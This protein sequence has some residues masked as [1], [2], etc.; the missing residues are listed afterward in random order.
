MESGGLSSLNKPSLG[1]SSPTTLGNGLN[2]ANDFPFS[3][4]NSTSGYGNTIRSGLDSTNSGGN[5][6]TGYGNTLNT[7]N[8]GLDTRLNGGTK[9]GQN[10]LYIDNLSQSRLF[11]SSL[12][13][14]SDDK[15][16]LNLGLYNTYL[17]PRIQL[18]NG[19]LVADNSNKVY[20]R[21]QITEDQKRE[22]DERIRREML[23]ELASST[24]EGIEP[25]PHID[26]RCNYGVG[27]GT[28]IHNKK[29][30]NEMYDWLNARGEPAD[31]ALLE[32]AWQNGQ[33]LINEN[34]VMRNG[35]AYCPTIPK[36]RIQAKSH[37]MGGVHI[38]EADAIRLADEFLMTKTF[39]QLKQSLKNMGM[40]YY[41]DFSDSG[42][43]VM[44]HGQYNLGKGPN[45]IPSVREGIL[46]NDWNKVC[47]GYIPST[48]GKDRARD[49]HGKC[50]VEQGFQDERGKKR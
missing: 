19:V 39:P 29:E 3:W 23:E 49:L 32:E 12:G 33:T 47:Q 9:N 45:A 13:S 26:T 6:D 24:H 35:K 43:K 37:G 34:K 50:G 22:I 30:F 1:E 16:K 7:A 31:A 25:T 20:E 27:I 5:L 36:A 4:G 15:Q 21:P 8:G 38:S 46:N 18:S 44:A 11:G 10:S 2:N 41:A 28:L 42:R 48:M 14:P 17:S 40:D